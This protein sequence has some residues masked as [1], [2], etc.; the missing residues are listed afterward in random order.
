MPIEV[1][2]SCGKRLRA[3]DDLAGKRAKCPGCGQMLTISA[4]PPPPAVEEEPDLYGFADA[5]AE[6]PNPRP[7]ARTAVA[8]VAAAAR[9]GTTMATRPVT[10]KP[11]LAATAA[12]PTQTSTRGRFVYVALLL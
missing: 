1:S 3:R 2:C 10:A 12:P 6:E 4:P 5:P 8:P 11:A 7:V 9:P